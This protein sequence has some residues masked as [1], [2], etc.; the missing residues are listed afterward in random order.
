P[1]LGVPRA[2]AAPLVR[3]PRATG[4]TSTDPP[5]SCDAS[6]KTFDRPLPHFGQP[7][8]PARRGMFVRSRTVSMMGFPAWTPTTG[9][10]GQR[11]RGKTTLH[12]VLLPGHTPLCLALLPGVLACWHTTCTEREG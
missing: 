4:S 12:G 3:R 5:H 10:L 2:G 8:P 6:V 1:R 11:G 7:C 9:R